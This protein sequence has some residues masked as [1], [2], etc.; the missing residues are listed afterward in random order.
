MPFAHRLTRC[1]DPLEPE[2]GTEAAEAVGLEGD[3]HRLV[4]GAAG[5]SPFLHRI[6]RQEAAWLSE[7]LHEEP[8]D[9]LERALAEVE[10]LADA[11]V[12]DGLRRAKRRVALL[13]ALADLGGVW[14]LGEVTGA[15]TRFAD[16]ACAT[17]L[18]AALAAERRRGRLPDAPDADGM[19]IFA[20]GKMGSSELNYS[21]DI[22]LIC[23]FDEARHP[24]EDYAEVR[25]GFVRA[26]RRMTALLSDNTEEGY[27]FRTDLRLRPDPSVT[28]VCIS[29]DAA[30]RYYEALGRAWERAAWIKARPAAGDLEAGGRFIDAL[31]PFVW[32]RHLDFVA[33]Q[34]AH[35]MRLRIREH[36][37]QH[38]Q[39]LEQRNVKLCPG[40]IRE[41]EFFTQTRQLIAGGRDPSLRVRGTQAAL[42]RLAA[43]GWV[44]ESD[45]GQLKRDYAFLREIEHRLQMVNDQQT[46]LLPQ[47]EAG[48]GRLAALCGRDVAGLR[49]ELQEVFDRVAGL[50]EDFF[51]PSPAAEG[52]SLTD[53]QKEIVS[54]WRSLPALRS[55]RSIEIFERLRPAL[56]DRVSKTAD[57]DRTLK[58]LT[59]FVSGL[60]AGVQIFSLFEANPQLLDLMTD[61]AASAPGLAHYLGRNAEVLDA[62][63]GGDF[64][65]D[66]PG[67]DELE[68]QLSQR[69]E[70][71][72]DYEGRLDTM[73]VWSKEWHFRIGVHLLRGLIGP[74]E[75]GH[76]YA[77][78]ADAVLRAVLPVAI[79]HFAQSH[80]PPPGRGLALL[81]MGSLGAALMTAASDLDLIVVYDAG[82][83]TT[84]AGRR[85]L[86]VRAYYAR[87][88]QALITALTAPTAHGRLYEV[89]MRLR[90]SGRQ[91]PVATSLASFRT[92]QKEEAW[93]WEHLALSR[94]R[95]VAGAP[96]VCADI[97]SLINDLLSPPQPADRVL[98]DTAG[99]RRRLEERTGESNRW[100]SKVGAGRLQDIELA[101]SAMALIGEGLP[102]DLAAA[103]ASGGRFSDE[104]VA[105]LANA[106]ALF[107]AV[108]ST[109]RLLTGGA[110]TEEAASDP[111]TL[112]LTGCADADDLARRMEEMAAEAARA[113]DGALEVDPAEDPADA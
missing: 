72:A 105:L 104:E 86:S 8:E 107:W 97:Q 73:R 82:E 16:L 37:G 29:M 13:T 21:S 17:A 89:D 53:A 54:G 91:G 47:D 59:A 2:H 12:A 113:I 33:I 61:I 96:S 63:I 14:H 43:A 90:P 1:P 100:E 69:L 92:Y 10:A 103:L 41:I 18:S 7:A 34:E 3:L 11:E 110:M 64:F 101:A 46:H 19:V 24:P 71:A 112:R 78:L 99:M 30:E 109:A 85:P 95:V 26:T 49:R 5:S 50:T 51:A 106:H 36:K 62:V 94:V 52:P 40:G 42:D 39:A 27:V 84:S 74:E 111:M 58:H 60:P 55:Q 15:L 9:A 57:P 66:W 102:R 80:G 20:M 98:R 32:R 83:E 65:A 68:A 4:S 75:A 81:G 35:A 87:L 38:G 88:T 45:A 6:A 25:S 28:P 31:R 44:S 76:Q 23:L 93:T 67:A 79:E 77:E 108:Q 70:A 56:F 22:D 48:F